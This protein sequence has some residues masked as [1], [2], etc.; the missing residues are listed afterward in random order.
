[1]PSGV[2]PI[3][4][5][6]SLTKP[7]R[8]ACAAS[9]LGIPHPKNRFDQGVQVVWAD[10]STSPLRLGLS[11]G[12]PPVLRGLMRLLRE[13]KGGAVRGAVEREQG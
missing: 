7:L 12:R 6:S 2:C 3:L 8:I 13:T 10:T 9:K 4:P 11:A 5:A 1:M